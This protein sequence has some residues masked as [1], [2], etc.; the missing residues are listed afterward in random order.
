[1]TTGRWKLGLMLALIASLMWGLLPIALKNLL[2]TM[3]AFTITWYRF[4]AAAALLGAFLVFKGRTPD[5]RALTRH[6]LI[7]LLVA[8][9][10]ICG[11]YILYL[12][13]LDFVSAGTAQMVIQ[14]SPMFLLF[15]G[16]ILFNEPFKR[17]QWV[18]FF[19]L[20]AGLLLYFNNRLDSIYASDGR[21]LS[22]IFIIV[23]AAV[24]WAAY[25]L[26]QKRLLM[27]LSSEQILLLIYIPSVFL[28]FPTAELSQIA[29]LD[30]LGWGL[31]IFC[32]LN[33]LVAYGCF[34]EALAHWEAS[35]ISAVLA[36]TPLITLGF[37]WCLRRWAPQFTA[38]EEINSLALFGAGL[39]VFGSMLTALGSRRRK[40]KDT[41]PLATLE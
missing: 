4:L 7:L 33:T 18:G 3:N 26:A 29:K 19:L 23:L 30:G 5:I 11:N 28:L 9:L 10:G 8:V 37:M 6:R 31:L 14:L 13:G 36:I 34:A 40:I 20:L 41:P 22:G 27:H 21:Y 25:A 38:P 1:M 32:S 17:I 15:G 39:V 16:L 24:V 12:I 35:R 2:V